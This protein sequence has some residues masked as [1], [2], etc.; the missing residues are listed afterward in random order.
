MKKENIV[1]NQN[2]ASTTCPTSIMDP[3]R[4]ASCEDVH[5]D[6]LN[7]KLEWRIDRHPQNNVT[8]DTFFAQVENTPNTLLGPPGFPYVHWTLAEHPLWIDFSKPTILDV[9]GALDDPNYIVVEGILRISRLTRF[10]TLTIII[11]GI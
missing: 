11:R 5:T 2:S 6:L 8:K 9:Q 10:L 3:R 1:S 4:N 7:P